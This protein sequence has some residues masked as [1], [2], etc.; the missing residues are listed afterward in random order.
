[1]DILIMKMK[2]NKIEETERFSDKYDVYKFLADVKLSIRDKITSDFVL[3]SLKEQDKIGCIEMTCNA[4][5]AKKLLSFYAVKN[6]E[7]KKISEAEMGKI[8][9]IADTVFNSYMN[10][11][12]MTVLLNRNVDRN[13][14]IKVLSNFKEGNEEEEIEIE[15]IRTEKK[16]KKK[17]NKE[18]E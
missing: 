2:E 4:Y 1:M 13:Y 14:I 12:Y 10:K 18:E 8:K 17:E 6:Y 3:A 5:I 11:I 15:D 16:K 9:L 7:L